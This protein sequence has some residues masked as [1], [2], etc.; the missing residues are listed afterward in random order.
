MEFSSTVHFVVTQVNFSDCKLKYIY[1]AIGNMPQIV[2]LS[3]HVLSRHFP[4]QKIFSNMQDFN[5]QSLHDCCCWM[6]YQSFQ[7]LTSVRSLNAP[8]RTSLWA[9][10]FIQMHVQLW[11]G[12]KSKL[13]CQYSQYHSP[14]N[15]LKRVSAHEGLRGK[16]WLF[17]LSFSSR[18]Q[19]SVLTLPPPPMLITE[20]KQAY[21]YWHRTTVVNI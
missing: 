18:V 17:T 14:L 5:N 12:K 10:T 20:K 9:T 8:L 11:L 7:T 19:V 1:A 3:T 13:S 21:L 6:G 4:K 2:F 15:T 16:T